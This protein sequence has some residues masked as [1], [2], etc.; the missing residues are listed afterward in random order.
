MHT[1]HTHI[2]TPYTPHAHPSHAHTYTI[3]TPCTP[4]T[5][6]YIHHTHPM[7]TAHT[8]YTLHLPFANRTNLYIHHTFTVL[9][10][11]IHRAYTVRA[12]GLPPGAL[13]VVSGLGSDA[14]A[15]L[16][17]HSDIDKISF[18]GTVCCAVLCC[19]VLWC[20]VMWCTV[21]RCEWR[22]SDVL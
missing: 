12:L 5:R 21:N 6:T 14:G 13:S 1:P 3:H 10:T 11:C 19:A 16:S 7:H 15:P 22:C 17:Q 4:L 9:T 8:P 20:D 18:T 2:H